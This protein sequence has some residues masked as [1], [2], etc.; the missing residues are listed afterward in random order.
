M[1]IFELFE[2][3]FNTFIQNWLKKIAFVQE[4]CL[5]MFQAM[6]EYFVLL[7]LHF[8]STSIFG[9]SSCHF[10]ARLSVFM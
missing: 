2:R 10:E 5:E 7:V 6:M 4:K 1:S 9:I 3:M 8:N